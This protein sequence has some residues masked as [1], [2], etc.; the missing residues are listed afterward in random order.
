M[1][2]DPA[3]LFYPGNWMKGTQLFSRSHKGAY[4]DLL[5]AQFSNGHLSL[6]DIGIILDSDYDTM[7]ESKLKPKFMI[8][9][10]GLY[11]NEFLESVVEE[12]NTYKR[13]R[14]D[15]LKGKKTS[16]KGNHKEEPHGDSLCSNKDKDK[17]LNKGEGKNAIENKDKNSEFDYFWKQYHTITG[18]PKTDMQAA[19]KKWNRLKPIEKNSAVENIRKWYESLRDKN[20]CKKARTYLEDKNFNDD[21]TKPVEQKYGVKNVPSRWGVKK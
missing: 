19:L 4:M 5:M 2:K 10:K 17:D 18:L 15:N 7:W 12:R 16:H 1:G 6:E 20:Y 13:G 14:L 21:F 3:F 9:D 8:D 11:Y